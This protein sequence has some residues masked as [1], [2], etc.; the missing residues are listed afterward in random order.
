MH[1]GQKREISRGKERNINQRR[2]VE[3]KEKSMNTRREKKG[4][5]VWKEVGGKTRIK[6]AWGGGISLGGLLSR[7]LRKYIN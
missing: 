5:D 4:R 6:S 1:S 7:D 2:K 3:R